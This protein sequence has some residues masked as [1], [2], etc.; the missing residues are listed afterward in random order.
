MDLQS[1]VLDELETNKGNSVSGEELATRLYVSRNAIW[2]AVRALK[3][4]GYQIKAVTNKGYCLSEN[5][6]LI[7]A[8]GIRKHL[9]E[10]LGWLRFE[11]RDT[12]TSTNTILKQ[13]AEQGEHEGKV[14]IANQQTVGRGRL[15]RSF[16]SPSQTGVYMSALLRPQLNAA[17]SLLITTAAAVAVAH[18]VQTVAG[19]EARIKWVND[20]FVDGRKAAG[21]LTEASLDFETGGL[22]Y[23][24]L[25]IGINV[26]RPNEDC[27]EEL[28]SIVSSLFGEEEQSAEIKSRLI[29]EVWNQFFTYY[30]RL[31]DRAFMEEYRR[32]SFVIGQEV[33]VVSGVSRERARVVDINNDAQL[34][35]R[36]VDGTQKQVSS[37]E[38][39]I[40]GDWNNES[41]T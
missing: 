5:N 7:S 18:A 20:I 13:M 2:K 35:V 19:R 22:S 34:I 3:E 26:S 38:V 25:G 31:T 41:K 4:K 12:V 6:R 21:I 16:Y 11:V 39:S 24:V 28:K 1:Q 36:L 23:V 27:P 30:P 9:K 15:G 10:T 8:P 17:D 37:G 33:E 29:A 40:R 14:L 32:L